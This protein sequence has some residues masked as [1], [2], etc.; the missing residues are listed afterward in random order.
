MQNKELHKLL[1]NL[2]GSKE[3]KR[4]SRQEIMITRQ[5]IQLQLTRARTFSVVR[6]MK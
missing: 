2:P 1:L 5:C 6:G 3:S 4:N